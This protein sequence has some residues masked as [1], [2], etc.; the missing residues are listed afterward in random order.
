MH[1]F[2][3]IVTFAIFWTFIAGVI[4]VP[5]YLRHKDRERMP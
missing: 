4:L 3:N 1:D 2:A 5:I